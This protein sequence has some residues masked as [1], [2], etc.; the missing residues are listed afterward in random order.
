MY[1]VAKLW[2]IRPHTSA[3]GGCSWK[4]FIVY[5]DDITFYIYYLIGYLCTYFHAYMYTRFLSCRNPKS[6]EFKT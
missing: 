1:C 4:I 6:F 3:V 5:C 2:T